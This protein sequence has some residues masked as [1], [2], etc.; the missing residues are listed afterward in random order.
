MRYDLNPPID[1]TI[2]DIRKIL[3]VKV[4]ISIGYDINNSGGCLLPSRSVP[5]HKKKPQTIP[6]GL[7]AVRTSCGATQY[8]GLDLT[9]TQQNYVY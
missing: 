3:S 5:L 4:L 9:V 7:N 1:P 6:A 8:G 2:V